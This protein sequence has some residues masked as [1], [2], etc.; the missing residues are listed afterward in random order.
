[1][2]Q[3]E[4]SAILFTFIKLPFVITIFVLYIFEW[5]TY[6]GFTVLDLEVDEKRT[7][8]VIY[9]CELTSEICLT[10]TK[11]DFLSSACQHSH[12]SACFLQILR[13]HGA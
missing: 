8:F 3:G 6:T 11:Y 1:M 4:H 10:H 7:T 2:L 9:L 5:L 13:M 12:K